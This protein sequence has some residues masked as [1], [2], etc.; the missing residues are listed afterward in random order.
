MP[1]VC[2]LPT[3]ATHREFY[4]GSRLIFRLLGAVAVIA[5][6]G[7]AH[8]AEIDAV[9]LDEEF[10]ARL[11]VVT[12]QAGPAAAAQAQLLRQRQQYRERSVRSPD[13]ATETRYFPVKSGKGALLAQMLTDNLLATSLP[14]KESVKVSSYANYD[15]FYRDNYDQN[16]TLNYD[17]DNAIDMLQVIG[18]TALVSYAEQLIAEAE[19]RPQVVIDVAVLEIS[20]DRSFD[21]GVEWN[22]A[23]ASGAFFKS[24]KNNFR[25]SSDGSEFTGA[26]AAT[27]GTIHDK[28]TIDAIL[29]AVATDNRVEVLSRPT[30]AVLS[31]FRAVVNVG[32][33]IPVV[34][35]QPQPGGA[36][37]VQTD[38]E[39]VGVNLDV[40]PTVTKDRIRLDIRPAVSEVTGY[41]SSGGVFSP[42]ISHSS[43]RTNVEVES[44]Q[45]LVLAGLLVRKSERLDR[46]LPGLKDVPGLRH[47]TGR[48]SR[49]TGWSQIIFLIKP[50]V[51]YQ[52]EAEARQ[53]LGEK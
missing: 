33:K 16:S 34:Q 23:N 9:R 8:Q 29:E 36:V 52:S 1:P 37:V 46:G 12:A 26:P 32:E 7:C 10:R 5:L 3:A 35:Y 43:M 28:V 40:L 20:Q 14:G 42:I 45:T 44:D 11:R 31:G 48:T 13:G 47:L 49:G 19:Y 41:S 27:F 50:R 17:R 4:P 53:A 22:L 18:P 2:P 6:T 51:L 21:V 30:L 25:L 15:W 39:Q 38:F 24:L